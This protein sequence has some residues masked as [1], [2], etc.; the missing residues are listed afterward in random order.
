M[1]SLLRFIARMAT[2][3]ERTRAGLSKLVRVPKME[4]ADLGTSSCETNDVVG[5]LCDT[6]M[7]QLKLRTD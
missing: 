7:P 6:A 3:N 4:D 5:G 2:T 1:R